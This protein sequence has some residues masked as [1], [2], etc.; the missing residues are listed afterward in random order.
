LII[1]AMPRA[2]WKGTISFGLV[3]IPVELVSA[4]AR[5]RPRFHLLHEKD[6]SPVRYD[7]VCQRESRVVPWDEIVKGYEYEKGHYTVLTKEDFKQAAVERTD[8]IDVLSFVAAGAIDPRFF[9]TP[10][11]LL[12]SSTPAGHAYALLREA[13]RRAG[14][15]G[16]A[17]IILRQEQHMAALWVTEKVLVLSMLRF[18]EEIQDA[19]KMS[20]TVSL[21]DERALRRNELEM[22]GRLIESFAGDWK[23][24]QYK[25]RYGA[26]LMAIIAAKEKGRKPRLGALGPAAPAGNVA[27]LMERL[28]A[29]LGQRKGAAPARKPAQPARAKAPASHRGAKHHRAGARRKAA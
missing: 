16:V 25:D 29:S 22:A 11:Y 15:V 3:T 4:V 28:R 19:A 24:E 6:E 18:A 10:Y 9:E 26:N 27:D 7:R 1:V 2:I 20:T 21:A 8:A 5:Q 12:P 13:M 23:P 14:K 17:Q